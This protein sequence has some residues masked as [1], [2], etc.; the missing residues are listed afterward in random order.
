MSSNENVLT[1]LIGNNG[2]YPNNEVLPLVLYKNVIYG[3][4]RTPEGFETLFTGNS[5]PAAWRNG[6]Y[7][8]HHF[9]SSAHEAL[10]IFSGWV[11]GIFGGPGGEV[12]EAEA[13]DVIVIPAGVSHCNLDQSHDFKVVGAYPEGQQYDMMTGKP[14]QYEKACQ[15]ILSVS[16]PKADPVRGK[17]GHLLELWK[18]TST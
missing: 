15:N 16:L 13:G 18:T 4:E 11:K 8:F 3:S 6:L 5:W 14:E 1:V 12:I 17:G 7:S 2:N 10:G 9:H